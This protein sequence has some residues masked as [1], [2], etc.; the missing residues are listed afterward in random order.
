MNSSSHTSDTVE[1]RV[2]EQGGE[3]TNFGLSSHPKPNTHTRSLKD[4]V[5]A[6]T[7]SMSDPDLS[8]FSVAMP[9]VRHVLQHREKDM[10]ATPDIPFSAMVARQITPKEASLIPAA[11]AAAEAER[12]RL[13]SYKT[14]SPVP[15]EYAEAMRT[16]KRL[17]KKFNFARIFVIHVIKGSE[18]AS[19]KHKAR[20]V[21][22]GNF[23]T[24][25]FRE[26][27]EF[28]ET[29]SSAVAGEG[30]RSVISLGCQK[31]WVTEQSDAESAYIQAVL[32]DGDTCTYVELPKGWECDAAKGLARPV[33]KL[34]RALYGHP[35]AGRVWQDHR[36]Q[37]L[38]QVGWTETSKGSSIFRHSKSQ[39][40]LAIY[41]DDFVLSAPKDEVKALWAQISSVISLDDPSPLQK[42]LGCD[43]RTT[44][45]ADH[46]T[47]TFD[48]AEFVRSCVD[49]Y[50]LVNPGAKLRPVSTPFC[51]VATFDLKEHLRSQ[52]NKPRNPQTW[53]EIDALGKSD[54][55]APAEEKGV[56]AGCAASIVMKILWAA[57][58][59]RPD[60]TVATTRLA[61]QIC[62]W[63][64]QSDK[65]L[66]RLVSYMDTTSGYL[67]EGKV[68]TDP[69]SWRLNVYSDA[70]FAGEG[71]RSTSG[72]YATLCS[73]A[74]GEFSFPITWASARQGCI[75]RS[76][77]EAEV[78]AASRAIFNCAIPLQLLW[79]QLHEKSL[80]V[81]VQEDNQA[82]IICL[83]R[84]FSPK[85]GYLARTHK[86]NL[87]AISEVLDKD[88]ISLDYCSTTLMRADPLTKAFS[89]PSWPAA[90]ELLLVR[91]PKVA[92]KT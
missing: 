58:C 24:D 37:R 39:A 16:C 75:S 71:C 29:A 81:A 77:P 86:V 15:V 50:K 51:D 27:V 11:C 52:Q 32:P 69:D 7:K 43:F 85:L 88:G 35:L 20:A 87:G 28:E 42:F 73:G 8:P 19:Q 10:Y 61:R 46:V 79:E 33:Y 60:L 89:G 25:M 47:V 44:R 36:N 68:S 38:S 1:E 9:C 84:G 30:F 59:A 22:G 64:T 17:G 66:H 72:L 55:V 90:L 63:T 18:G 26:K 31:D 53:E 5:K 54:V 80:R 6:M 70:D 92:C 41:V 67:L 4:G 45:H 65:L 82:A 12:L 56:L 14:W 48:M 74:N 76:T 2:F 91:P 34:E 83:K 40:R 23:V 62:S 21:F 57:R 13:I 78:V 3:L 49:A